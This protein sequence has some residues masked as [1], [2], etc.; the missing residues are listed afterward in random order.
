MRVIAEDVE[1]LREKPPVIVAA[2]TATNARAV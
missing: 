1:L 2:A